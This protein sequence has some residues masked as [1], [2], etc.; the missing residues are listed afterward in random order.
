MSE[1]HLA[2]TP[3]AGT[4]F[5]A[6]VSLF[7]VAKALKDGMSDETAKQSVPLVSILLAPFT[8]LVAVGFLLAVFLIVG[9][10]NAAVY[11]VYWLRWKISGVEFPPKQ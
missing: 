6:G 8:F 4:R 3:P 7:S 5:L 9:T 11:A 10:W 2:R 1:T